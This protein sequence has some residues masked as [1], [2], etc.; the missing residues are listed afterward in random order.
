MHGMVQT[1]EHVLVEM[2]YD[3]QNGGSLAVVIKPTI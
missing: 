2:T 3:L 1:T